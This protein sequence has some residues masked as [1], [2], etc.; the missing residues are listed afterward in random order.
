MLIKQ[1][2]KPFAEYSHLSRIFLAQKY[3]YKVKK[4]KERKKKRKKRKKKMP[5]LKISL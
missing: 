3:I 2:E 1:L 4:K 5:P